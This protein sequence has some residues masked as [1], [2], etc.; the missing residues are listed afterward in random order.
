MRT[1]VAV[2]DDDGIHP[3][4]QALKKTASPTATCWSVR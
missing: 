3:I 2:G 4:Y 1:I